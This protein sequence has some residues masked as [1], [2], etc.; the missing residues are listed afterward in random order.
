MNGPVTDTDFLLPKPFG[1]LANDKPRPEMPERGDR[2][3]ADTSGQKWTRWDS[4]EV[5]KWKP[6]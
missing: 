4:E 3:S 5:A 2:F 1:T 6:P